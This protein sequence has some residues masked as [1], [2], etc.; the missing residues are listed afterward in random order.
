[1]PSGYLY[2]PAVGPTGSIDCQAAACVPD[3]GSSGLKA[4]VV[5]DCQGEGVERKESM[6]MH[7]D[8]DMESYGI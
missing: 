8:T 3:G 1:M 5:K 2:Y 7:L 4:E 6:R